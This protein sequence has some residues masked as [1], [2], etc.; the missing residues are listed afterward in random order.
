MKKL[1][2]SGLIVIL[3]VFLVTCDDFT[4][5]S[6]AAGGSNDIPNVQYSPDGKSVTL[7]LDG[8]GTSKKADR[9]LTDHIAQT[10]YDYLE[11]VFYDG[12]TVAR[13]Q[14]E[15]GEPA[16]I[17]NVTRGVNYGA[18]S[19]AILFAGNKSD[20]TLLAV[21]LL[22]DTAEADGLLT[23]ST[24]VAVDTVTATFTLTAL[25]AGADFT[26]ASSSFV[27][28]DTNVEPSDSTQTPV[29]GDTTISTLSHDGKTFPLYMIPQ[30]VP[31]T[32]LGAG[33]ELSRTDA[34]Y[35][36]DCT[37]ATLHLAGYTDGIIVPKG[38]T[39]KVEMRSPRYSIGNGNYR[40]LSSPYAYG[41]TV[42]FINNIT[43]TTAASFDPD[44]AFKIITTPTDGIIAFTFELP[45]FALN[46]DPMAGGPDA[47]TWYIR[48][49]FLTNRYDLDDGK[50]SMGGMIALGIGE[51]ISLNF[52][53]INTN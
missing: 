28:A 29:A 21:G 24:T 5:S 1:L 34:I 11:V 25:T 12:T 9:A 15:I 17:K 51:D 52:L 18:S 22:T 23:G 37:D 36:I 41:T 43:T 38:T 49:G 10:F 46:D 39:G 27:T 53:W 47:L 50:G 19:A 16:G 30:Y 48:P 8:G 2:F 31:E 6:K 42:E 26:A 20:R 44:I 13:A 35:T 32:S 4:P 3:A 7:R 14:W 33:D 45:V 40:T